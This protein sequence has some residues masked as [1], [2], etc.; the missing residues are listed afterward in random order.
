MA[1]SSAAVLLVLGYL[2]QL[3]DVRGTLPG[4]LI[5]AGWILTLVAAL[6]TLVALAAL[7]CTA[8]CGRGT[9]AHHARLEQARLDWQQALL[10]HGMLPHLRRHLGENPPLTPRR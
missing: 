1:A 7:L 9:P 8:I 3:T 5:T 2:L 4:S 10:E 6:S